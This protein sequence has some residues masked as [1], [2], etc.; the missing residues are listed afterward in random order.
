MIAGKLQ[1]R[2]LVEI[3]FVNTCDGSVRSYPVSAKRKLIGFERR[4]KKAAML[5]TA[6]T[7]REYPVPQIMPVIEELNPAPTEG[8]LWASLF[9][10]GD[11]IPMETFL[12]VMTARDELE[13]IPF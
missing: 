4:R 13:S 9:L 11:Y 5:Q 3:R 1:Q 2:R 6:L 12:D 7:Q 8:Q 10:G